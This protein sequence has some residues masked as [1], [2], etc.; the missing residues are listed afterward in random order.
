ML[1]LCGPYVNQDMKDAT[2]GIS[3]GY[4]ILERTRQ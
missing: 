1:G 3:D 4:Y 2:I